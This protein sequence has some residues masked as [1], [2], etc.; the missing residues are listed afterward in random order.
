[1]VDQDEG[2]E[3]I[4]TDDIVEAE[5]AGAEEEAVHVE[6]AD[7]PKERMSVEAEDFVAETLN[8]AE[9]EEREF[10]ADEAAEAVEAG[11]REDHEEDLEEVVR[12]HYGIVEEQPDEE[13]TRD[14]RD[15]LRELGPDEFICQSCFMRRSASQL[16]DRAHGVSADCA[17]R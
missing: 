14:E 16:S 12:R 17:A 3:F 6:D 9:A 4:P 15:G 13:L 10:D 11:A 8:E 2:I 1:M 7:Q 5:A